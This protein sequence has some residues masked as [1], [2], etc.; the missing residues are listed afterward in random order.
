MVNGASHWSLDVFVCFCN[1]VGVFAVLME[2]WKEVLMFSNLSKTLLSGSC[3]CHVDV[4]TALLRTLVDGQ[5]TMHF[6]DIGH[7]KSDSCVKH[8]ELQ[9]STLNQIWLRMK[10]LQ[11]H[12][13]SITSPIS[14]NKVLPSIMNHQAILL[15]QV[16]PLT[17]PVD[18][19]DP[20]AHLGDCCL[21]AASRWSA[22]GF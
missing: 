7:H 2:G 10:A 5:W 13:K 15:Q 11:V 18:P 19:M 4:S 17:F 9:T 8:W 1:I 22:G 20:G 3:F 6:V 21:W 14:L 16:T 12:K